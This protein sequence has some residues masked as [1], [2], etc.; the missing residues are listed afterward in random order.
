MDERGE[1]F[2]AHV[3]RTSKI[4]GW[5]ATVMIWLILAV[6]AL[7]LLG[8]TWVSWI[9]A[10]LIFAMIGGAFFAQWQIGKGRY[11][12]WM[13]AQAA[14][15]LPHF[16]GPLSVGI[17]SA[18]LGMP[19]FIVLAGLTLSWE[20][21]IRAGAL[22]A[23]VPIAGWVIRYRSRRDA[24]RRVLFLKLSHQR[25][26][27]IVRRVVG[28]RASDEYIERFLGLSSAKGISLADPAIVILPRAVFLKTS[29]ISIFPLEKIENDTLQAWEEMILAEAAKEDLS[30][31]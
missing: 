28:E 17:V 19:L 8:I 9:L 11:G 4:V 2:A 30:T 23:F 21:I 29:T 7:S 14:F 10:L 26:K 3:R 13:D 25:V 6:I 16:L 24:G 31:S 5:G 1:K 12:F 18:S 27:G 20:I 22:L 15:D